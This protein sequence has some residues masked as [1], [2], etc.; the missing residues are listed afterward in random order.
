MNLALINMVTFQLGWFACVV[1]AARGYPWLGPVMVALVVALHLR[2]IQDRVGEIRLL[3][4]ASVV[5]F[6]LDSAQVVAG[7]FSFTTKGAISGWPSWVSPPWMVALWC[8]FATT[9]HTSLSWLAGR[10]QLASLLGAVGGPLSYYAG[11]RLGAISLP[12]ELATSLLVI[13]L[14]WAVAM[15]TLLWA[16]KRRSDALPRYSDKQRL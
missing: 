9:L 13:G 6:L 10:Y 4:F 15:P 1:G 16:S 8:A 12:E 11:A 14:V 7:V 5:G 2:L 3:F